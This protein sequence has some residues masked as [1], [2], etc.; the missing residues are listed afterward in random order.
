MPGRRAVKTGVILLGLENDEDAAPDLFSEPGEKKNEALT[1][2]MD[3]INSQFGRNSV[4]LMGE[5][6]KREWSMRQ[7]FLSKHFT[8]RWDDLLT[9]K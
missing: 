9:V 5:G 7:E 3:K 4:F 2:A 8:T 1:E 6:I